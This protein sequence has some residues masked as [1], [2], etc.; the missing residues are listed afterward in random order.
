[1]APRTI[2]TIATLRSK[3]DEVEKA[4][5]EH[6]RRLAKARDDFNHL[7]GAIALFEATGSVNSLFQRGEAIA[8]CKRALRN[9]PLT[10]QAMVAII[11]EA[12]GFDPGDVMIF[13][14]ILA[15]LR[16]ALY[17]QR[18]RGTLVAEGK[19][20]TAWIWRLP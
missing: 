19:L 14:A 11:M 16:N 1:M 13:T 17:D 6:E 4:I 15:R 2:W 5:A 20:R 8:I 10:A 3:R 18:R 9:G 7:S 12:K